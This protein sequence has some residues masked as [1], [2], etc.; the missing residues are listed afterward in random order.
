MISLLRKGIRGISGHKMMS[1]ASVCIV[2]AVFALLGIFI[3]VGMN[4]GHVVELLG[5]SRE[6][7]VYIASDASGR[8][9]EDIKAE[10]SVLEGAEKVIYRSKEDRMMT[11]A[12]QIYGESG[13]AEELN[14][15]ILRD[16]FVIVAKDSSLVANISKSAEEVE[17]VEE[18]VCNADI[19]KNI[20]AAANAVLRLGFLI[21]LILLLLVVFIICNTIRLCVSSHADE[22]YLMQLIGAT[23]GFIMI[24]YMVQ[25]VL[26]GIFGAFI[27]SVVVLGLYKAFESAALSMISQEILT[28]LP[29]GDIALAV[30]CVYCVLSIGIGV[31]GAAASVGRDLAKR[32]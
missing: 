16:S 19:I 6:I 28:F 32:S 29:V 18:I 26:L 11:V 30:I 3:A 23:D 27:A 9:I 17:G 14:C 15:D 31:V 20:D 2:A 4:V 12:E 21:M 5:D 24:P 7:N 22:I 13:D 8:K 25:G 10:L 1:A